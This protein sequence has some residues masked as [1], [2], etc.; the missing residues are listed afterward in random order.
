MDH[1][2]LRMVALVWGSSFGPGVTPEEVDSKSKSKWFLAQHSFRRVPPDE[3]LRTTCRRSHYCLTLIILSR[4][5]HKRSLPSPSPAACCS[6]CRTHTEA[7]G[8]FIKSMRSTTYRVV[9]ENL[10][11]NLVGCLKKVWG[12]NSVSNKG[13]LTSARIVD[14]MTFQLGRQVGGRLQF[15][16]FLD[17]KSSIAHLRTALERSEGQTF[18]PIGPHTGKKGS[19]FVCVFDEARF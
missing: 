10:R 17:V 12:E 2:L 16:V 7:A 13:R 6:A 9:R 19:A 15:H 11:I 5:D 14:T 4:R 8:T 3:S 18:H 1:A